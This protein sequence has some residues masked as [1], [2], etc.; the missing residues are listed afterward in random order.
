MGGSSRLF[1]F[2]AR[3]ALRMNV[4][5]H[6]CKWRHHKRGLEVRDMKFDVQICRYMT[7]IWEVLMFFGSDVEIT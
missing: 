4:T 7:T 5:L 6:P 1:P 2:V 3:I